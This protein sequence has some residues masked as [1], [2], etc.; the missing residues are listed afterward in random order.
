MNKRIII[1]SIAVFLFSSHVVNAA[2][3][4]VKGKDFSAVDSGEIRWGGS[5]QYSTQWYAAIYTWSALNKIKI[6]PD[7]FYTFED[8]TVS[9]VL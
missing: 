7:T 6:L 8:L 9:D 5:T 2:T 3:N 4:Y 1:L